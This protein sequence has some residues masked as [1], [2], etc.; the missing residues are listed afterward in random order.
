MV[1]SNKCDETF[2]AFCSVC[3]LGNPKGA[4]ITHRNM[5]SSG[6]ATQAACEVLTANAHSIY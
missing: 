6:S 2:V 3:V 1:R 5:I 4:V